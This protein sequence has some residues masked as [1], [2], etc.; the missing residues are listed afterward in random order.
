MKSWSEAETQA[1]GGEPLKLGSGMVCLW[2]LCS[3][4]LKTTE[5][6]EFNTEWFMLCLIDVSFA[7]MPV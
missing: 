2:L 4:N 1:Q 5:G 6:T 7:A 3:G